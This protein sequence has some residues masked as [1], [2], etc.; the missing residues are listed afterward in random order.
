M[1]EGRF[2]TVLLTQIA[3]TV[4]SFILFFG[5]FILFVRCGERCYGNGGVSSGASPT[6]R[7]DG[8]TEGG[9]GAD[10]ER[11]ESVKKRLIVKVRSID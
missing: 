5:F 11:K 8:N 4:L 1:G 2:P 10:D 3:A 7:A 6:T 9:D